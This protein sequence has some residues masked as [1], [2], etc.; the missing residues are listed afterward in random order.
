MSSNEG[1]KPKILIVDDDVSLTDTL[2]QG[3]G[4]R[5]DAEILT[6]YDGLEA[7][8]IFDEVRPEIVILDLMLPKRGGFQLLQTWKGKDEMKGK[9]PFVIMITGNETLRHE[10]FAFQNGID[11]YLRKPFSVSTLIQLIEEYLRKLSEEAPEW[12]KPQ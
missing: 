5:F 12:A 1:Q 4:D 2:A 9:L 10:Q 11:E 6:A 8:E 7:S 3:I